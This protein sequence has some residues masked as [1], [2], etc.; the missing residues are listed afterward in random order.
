MWP[1]VNGFPVQ[2]DKESLDRF[3]SRA[4]KQPPSLGIQDVLD[5]V[6]KAFEVSLGQMASASRWSRLQEARGACA[7]LVRE[8]S[9]VHFRSLVRRLKRSE[10]TLGRLERRHRKQAKAPGRPHRV[11]PPCADG[12]GPSSC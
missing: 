6:A 4:T 10:S 8:I 11:R 7:I 5:A 9:G 2:P 12:A 1:P 3:V